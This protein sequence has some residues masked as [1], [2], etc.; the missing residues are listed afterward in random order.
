MG[1]DAEITQE[2]VDQ[3]IRNIKGGRTWYENLYEGGAETRWD[4]E[5][6]VFRRKMWQNNPYTGATREGEFTDTEE[7][8]RA[9]MLRRNARELKSILS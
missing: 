3:A 5:A 6:K 4:S 7:A 2:Q 9:K 1:L 8:V